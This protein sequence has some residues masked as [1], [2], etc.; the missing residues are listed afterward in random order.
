MYSCTFWIGSDSPFCENDIWDEALQ[1]FNDGTHKE[2]KTA[3]DLI[4]GL[5]EEE[6]V[7]LKQ[8][9]LD[10]FW[11][12]Y[13]EVSQNKDDDADL[14][15]QFSPTVP[16]NLA[17]YLGASSLIWDILQTRCGFGLDDGSATEDQIVEWFR[18]AAAN[19][20][21][22]DMMTLLLEDNRVDPDSNAIRIASK[23]GNVEVVRLLLE[24]ERV[25]PAAKNNFAIR[26]ASRNGHVE[27]VRLL[28]KDKRVDPAADYNYAIRMASAKRA[29][30]S[31]KIIA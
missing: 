3:L 9:A 26:W 27:V 25:D 19:E 24:D 15:L 28:L 23:N 1:L 11:N 21:G 5:I 18:Y 29:C 4:V 13:R 8:E 22:K 17:S 20:F 14:M 7:L 12:T 16:G 10:H 30:G 2:W 31:R 6:P